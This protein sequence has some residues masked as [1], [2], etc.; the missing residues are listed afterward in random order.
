MAGRA[1]KT[2]PGKAPD[3]GST[4]LNITDVQKGIYCA[5]T[6]ICKEC[7]HVLS[8]D[9]RMRLNKHTIFNLCLMSLLSLSLLCQPNL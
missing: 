5:N 4:P 8:A 7:R 9:N 6:T 3:N 2:K 1:S